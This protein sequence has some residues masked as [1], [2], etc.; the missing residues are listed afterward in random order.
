[1]NTNTL[2]HNI[3]IGTI[4]PLGETTVDYLNQMMHH[5]FESVQ[6]SGN[7]GILDLDIEELADKVRTKVK[8][9]SATISS[10]FL[11]ANPMGELEDDKKAIRALE[12]LIDNAHLFGVSLVCAFTGRVRGASIPDSI[13]RFHEIWR[14]LTD[15]AGEKGIRLAFE[16]CSMGG[17]WNTGDWNIAHS[18]KAWELIFESIP[19]DHLGLEWE[20]CH[21]MV[22]LMDPMPQ[23]REWAGKMF[24]L[25]GKDASIHHDVIARYGLEGG[26]PWAFH[27]T[28]GFGDTNWTD[29]ISELR[30]FGF[31]GSID[32]EGWHDPVY[33]GELEMTGQVH[34]LNY[35]KRCRGG[36]FAANPEV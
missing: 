30:R 21:Q 17:T 27:R 32:I 8:S 26:V 22:L 2:L 12:L 1:M 4:V 31:K 24:H 15:R 16:N 14:P 34:A 3:R 10:F 6:L 20:P 11:G 25:H 29:V 35:L 18:P 9:Y 36:E 5:G 19:D 28:P 13:D 33:V 23:L 7:I